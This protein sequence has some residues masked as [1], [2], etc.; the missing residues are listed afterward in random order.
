MMLY[1][2]FS[3]ILLLIVKSVFINYCVL[4]FY[5]NGRHSLAQLL[6]PLH[7]RPLQ[8]TMPITYVLKIII[9]FSKI[10]FTITHFTIILSIKNLVYFLILGLAK[11]SF[12]YLL[13]VIASVINIR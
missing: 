11:R 13:I 5:E 8:C 10:L 2:I 4:P 6:E 12:K 7:Q 3:E 9:M 1:C